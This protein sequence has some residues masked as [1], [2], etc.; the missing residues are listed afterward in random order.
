MQI[1]N[2]K[3]KLEYLFEGKIE[4]VKIIPAYLIDYINVMEVDFI[5]S[6]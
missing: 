3:N 6:N 4:I 1:Y 2:L 5:I